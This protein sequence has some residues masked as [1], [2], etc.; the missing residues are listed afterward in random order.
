MTAAVSK[1][2]GPYLFRLATPRRGT[3]TLLSVTYQRCN[4]T[5]Y[6]VECSAIYKVSIDISFGIYVTRRKIFGIDHTSAD[7]HSV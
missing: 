7:T 5:V 3:I 6:L 2:A 1:G 4:D